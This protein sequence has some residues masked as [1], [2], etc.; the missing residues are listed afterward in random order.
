MWIIYQAD[1]SHVSTYFL[2]KIKKNKNNNNNNKNFRVSS[3]RLDISGST[4][5]SLWTNSAGIF[6]FI[7]QVPREV[8]KTVASSVGF[9]HLPR[10]T[11]ND[12]SVWM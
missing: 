7:R 12:Q 1:N 2:W 10:D 11:I 5:G 8:L 9:Q 3:G 6:F 4:S